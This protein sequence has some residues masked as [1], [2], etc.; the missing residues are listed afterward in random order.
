MSCFD[1]LEGIVAIGERLKRSRC[2]R[3]GSG[4]TPGWRSPSGSQD[5]E[6]VKSE[7]AIR[8]SGAR[9]SQV[10]SCALKDFGNEIKAHSRTEVDEFLPQYDRSLDSSPF[11][12]LNLCSP[13]P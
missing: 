12:S 3:A 13:N 2:R 8:T 7:P 10:W 4:R 11:P 1:D 6:T 9:K 5:A